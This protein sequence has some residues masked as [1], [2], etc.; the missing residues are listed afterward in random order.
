MGMR[1]DAFFYKRILVFLDF[2]I[3]FHEYFLYVATNQQCMNI[4][5]HSLGMGSSQALV[6]STPSYAFV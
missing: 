4:S 2:K 5:S 1:L 3:L 6:Q